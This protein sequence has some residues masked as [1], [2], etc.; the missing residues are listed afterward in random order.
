LADYHA[1]GLRVRTALDLPCRRARGRYAADVRLHAA[2]G[3]RMACARRDIASPSP[4]WF[5]HRT[6]AD[7]TIYL[8]WSGLFEFLVSPDGSRIEY[9]ALERSTAESFAVYL[10]GQV[11]SFSLIAFGS[12]PLHGTVVSVDG[13]AIALLGDCGHG[14]ST[15]GAALLSRG[16]GLVTDD[17]VALFQREG[18]WTVHPGIPRIKLFPATARRLLGP[19]AG[20]SPM[21]AA[22]PKL[23]IPL[24]RA[25]VVPRAVPLA[26][27]YVLSEPRAA[28]REITI[29]PLAKSDAFLEVVRG[30]FNLTVVTPRR[31]AN[32][33]AFATDLASLV[34]IRRISYPRTFSSLP[35]VCDAILDD[36]SASRDP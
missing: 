4:R 18:R 27:I 10:L 28:S 14:K 25:Q 11:L 13:R 2:S 35:A 15:L 31:L 33:F 22:T 30:A 17:V 29:E 20:G 7:G 6:L 24:E 32:Q 34:P 36:L 9:C 26:G 16:C 1:F 8:R 3:G 12:E 5:H 21:N 19:I 23:V